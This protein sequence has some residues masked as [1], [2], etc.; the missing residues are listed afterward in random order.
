M[1]LSTRL[2]GSDVLQTYNK[3]KASNSKNYIKS[4]KNF[5][6]NQEDSICLELSSNAFSTLMILNR[7]VGGWTYLKFMEDRVLYCL[8]RLIQC[9]SFIWRKYIVLITAEN[10]V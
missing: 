8:N 10:S 1:G 7:V 6:G 9:Y 5:C 4:K 2:T 3:R